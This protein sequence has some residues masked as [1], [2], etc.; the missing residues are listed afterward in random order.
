MS[1]KERHY[2]G[3]MYDIFP[4]SVNPVGVV[5]FLTIKVLSWTF[6]NTK[7]G[8]VAWWRHPFLVVFSLQKYVFCSTESHWMIERVMIFQ[9]WPISG[10]LTIIN[11]HG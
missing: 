1:F 10:K 11:H 7:K 5:N 8:E 6:C 4:Q 2:V 9:G 3:S